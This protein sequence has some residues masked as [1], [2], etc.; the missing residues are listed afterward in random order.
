[1][2]VGSLLAETAMLPIPVHVVEKSFVILQILRV[3][4]Q[5][6]VLIPMVSQVLEI[7]Q[8]MSVS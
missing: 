8:I 5:R 7:D 4:Q 3:R 2:S 1:M 6:D